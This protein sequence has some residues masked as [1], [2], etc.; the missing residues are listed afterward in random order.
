VRVPGE[1]GT[2]ASSRMRFTLLLT[3]VSAIAF[4]AATIAL[5]RGQLSTT[6]AEVI[7]A[8]ALAAFVVM[9][10]GLLRLVLGLV[11]TAGERRRQEREVSERRKGARARKPR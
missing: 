1:A 2:P 9:V 4:A 8:L 6:L 10:Y 7:A 3:V 5:L 11:E